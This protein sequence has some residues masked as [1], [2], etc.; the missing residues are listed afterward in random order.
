VDRGLISGIKRM[1]PGEYDFMYG[2]LGDIESYFD[3]ILEERR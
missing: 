2:R 3:E 1:S